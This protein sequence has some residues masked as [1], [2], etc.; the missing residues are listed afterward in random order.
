MYLLHFFLLAIN[1]AFAY[2]LQNWLEEKQTCKL[3]QA[4]VEIKMWIFCSVYANKKCIQHKDDHHLYLFIVNITSGAKRH[5]K[6][7]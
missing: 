2:L 1:F 4:A 5:C 7:K 3:L 6:Q